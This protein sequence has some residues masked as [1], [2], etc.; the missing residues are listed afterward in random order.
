M[1]DPKLLL[2]FK[3]R[4]VF[5][6]ELEAGTISEDRHLCFIKDQKRIWC[7]GQFY[8][9][10]TKLDGIESY[11]DDWSLE[12]TNSVVNIT[13][14]GHQWNDSSN[15]WDTITKALT[16]NAATHELA[17]VV[18]AVDKQHIDTSWDRSEQIWNGN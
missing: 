6:K 3:T 1:V 5:D 2:H 14:K 16:I 12:H 8:Y 10:G 11:Y 13:L 9:C 18:T 7:R 15:Q 17:G 4:A